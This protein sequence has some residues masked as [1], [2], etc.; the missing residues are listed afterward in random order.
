ME[1]AARERLVG[2]GKMSG[3]SETPLASSASVAAA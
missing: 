1:I 3:L 2:F